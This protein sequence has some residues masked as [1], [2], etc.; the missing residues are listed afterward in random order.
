MNSSPF[1]PV[2]MFSFMQTQSDIPGGAILVLILS[3]Q[4]ICSGIRTY[5]SIRDK[6]VAKLLLRTIRKFKKT[7]NNT[8]EN[9]NNDFIFQVNLKKMKLI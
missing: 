4:E 9:L 5:A 2:F 8:T 6:R 3:I 7:L 1:L